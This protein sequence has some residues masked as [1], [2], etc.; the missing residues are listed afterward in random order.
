METEGAIYDLITGKIYATIQA[1]DHEGLILERV[2]MPAGRELYEGVTDED[3]YIDITQDP[4]VPLPK[5]E[6]VEDFDTVDIIADGVDEATLSGLEPGTT[7][8]LD[9]VPYVVGNDGIFIF[10][11]SDNGAYKI[12]VDE[13]KFFKK[14]WTINAD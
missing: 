8:Y 11:T 1:Q 13:A 3:H 9:W 10:V 6:L 4:V 14:E 12:H 2:N 7:V 5:T